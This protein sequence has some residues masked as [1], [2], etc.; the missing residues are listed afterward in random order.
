MDA[1]TRPISPVSV[2]DA[3]AL[4]SLAVQL[5]YANGQA[6]RSV[7]AQ[8]ERVGRSIGYSVMLFPGWGE[9]IVRLEAVDEPKSP[10]IIAI[11]CAPAGVD[12]NKVIKT[13]KV[14]DEVSARRLDV[15]GSVAA[16]NEIARL[17]PTST[18]RF[19]GLAGA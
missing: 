15:I 8:V 9:L 5:L 17:G 2:G 6:T 19:A 10:K 1:K 13:V 12:M 3:S 18:L 14:L 16:L 11:E 4:L 7:I